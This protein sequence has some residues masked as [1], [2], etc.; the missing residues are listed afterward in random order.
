MISNY[1]ILSLIRENQRRKREI[2]K[3]RANK[4]R[5]DKERADK[6][7]TEKTLRSERARDQIEAMSLDDMAEGTTHSLAQ[8]TTHSLAQ[9]TGNSLPEDRDAVVS[10][11][12]F[13]F[14]GCPSTYRLSDI[15]EICGQNKHWCT[16][17]VS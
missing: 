8:G 3:E 7:R 9:G 12:P 11:T 15:C 2:D 10:E 17:Q 4:E 1:Y 13:R 14:V 16:C 6:E 5:A